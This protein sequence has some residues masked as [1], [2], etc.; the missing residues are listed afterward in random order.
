MGLGLEGLWGWVIEG[1]SGCEFVDFGFVCCVFGFVDLC[2][3][4]C[5]FVFVRRVVFVLL[6]GCV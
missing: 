3:F 5:L 4:G 2:V 1:V 6:C